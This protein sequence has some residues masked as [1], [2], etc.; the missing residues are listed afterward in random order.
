MQKQCDLY[1]CSP[2]DASRLKIVRLFDK[3][4]SCDD[5]KVVDGYLFVNISRVKLVSIVSTLRREHIPCFSIP[6]EYRDGDISLEAACEVAKN[7][8]E[9]H[10]DDVGI[11]DQMQY[12]PLFWSFSL[13]PGN[14]A[15]KKAGGVL[16][17]D[18]LDG[19]IWTIE[20][21]EEY[22]YDYNNVF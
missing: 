2:V 6:V 7:Y 16:M 4:F 1:L 13:I 5:G 19:H 8:A 18:R 15:E 22:M 10:G 17:V 9:S 20:E 12:P 3:S 11:R 14:S 21:Y